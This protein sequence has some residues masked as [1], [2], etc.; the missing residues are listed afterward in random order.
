MRKFNVGLLIGFFLILPVSA[1]AIELTDYLSPDFKYQD[2]ELSARFDFKDGNQEQ[3]SYNG[4]LKLEYDMEYS[5]L[6]LKWEVYAE[7]V[8]DF[9]RGPNDRD[10]SEKN[11]SIEGWT[12]A[13][14]YLADHKGV[15]G[16]GRFDLGI[17][18]IEDDTVENDDPY[19]KVTAG[20]GKGRI[21]TATPLMKAVRCVED[22]KKYDIISDEISDDTYMELAAIIARESEY[23][24]KY[25][26]VEYEK[27]WYEDMEKA[28]K[29]A[30]VL[31]E[32]YLGAMGVIR[33]QDILTYEPVLRRKHGWEAGAGIE[34]L[35]SDYAGNEGD[36]GLLGYFEYA[37]PYGFKW[38]FID[39][40]EYSTVLPD[41]DFGDANHNLFNQAWLN[42]EMTDRVDWVNLF[43]L[44]IT[45]IS[46][47]D[48]I[49]QSALNTGLRF[50]ISNT[51]DAQTGLRFDRFDQ[52]DNED[53]EVETRVYF[54]VLYTIF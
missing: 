36:P 28:L 31:K 13:Q 24:S 54:E 45:L 17:R 46:G 8:A 3:A 39:R 49:Y 52:G 40:V 27:F 1:I 25:S 41:W 26:L 4:Q 37:K 22:L 48:D 43:E 47:G 33:I 50:Y 19:L 53:D 11:I 7:G 9:N 51:I 30:G 35:I 44:G 5:T 23:K 20:M 29:A 15:F 2:A 12:S 21:I 6:P 38:Q 42:Y 18:D 10:S 16:F 14:K 34:Y 32:E